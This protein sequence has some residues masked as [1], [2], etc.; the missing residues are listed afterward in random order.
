MR[1]IAL[2]LENLHQGHL[3]KQPAHVLWDMYVCDQM[4]IGAIAKMLGVGPRTITTLLRSFQIQKRTQSEQKLVDL[5]RMSYGD[6]LAMTEASRAIVKGR[7]K[8]HADLCKRAKTKQDRAV[9]SGDEA[10]IVGHMQHAGLDPVPLL[11]VDK[12]NIDFGFPD[13]KVAVEYHGGNW[14]NSPKKRAQDER[15]AAYLRKNGWTLLVFPRIV[16]LRNSVSGNETIAVE[17][18]VRR[19]LDAIHSAP[20][21]N[22]SINGMMAALPRG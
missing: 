8:T 12:Y 21:G 3:H 15:K 18:I 7:P 5:E 9:L 6:R 1:G 2:A 13:E 19:T 14:H 16:K 11:A 20:S 10:I 22:S 17:E 4:S